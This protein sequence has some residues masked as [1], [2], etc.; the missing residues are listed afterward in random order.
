MP[1][2]SIWNPNTQ[3]FP[4]SSLNIPISVR[5][6]VNPRPIPSPSNIDGSTLFLEA[7][8]SARPRMIQFT[9]I[10][11]IYSPRLLLSDGRYACS[12]NCMIVTNEAMITIN[13]GILTLSGIT[14]LSAEIMKLLST[15]IHVVVSPIPAPLMA[16]DVTASVGHIPS[17]CTKVGFSFTIPLY[18][19]SVHFPITCHLRSTLQMNQQ[20]RHL[21]TSHTQVPHSPHW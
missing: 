3:P 5:P 10:S 1:S 21:W 11:G 17:I 13:D 16:D 2:P 18:K 8:A 6:T 9:T 7:Y 4:T 15:R 20:H 14:F 19:R 12:R